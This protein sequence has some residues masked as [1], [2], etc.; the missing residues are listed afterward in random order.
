MKF[1]TSR[2]L[3]HLLSDVLICC[4]LEILLLWQR[5]VTTSPL[6]IYLDANKFGLLSFFALLETICQKVRAKPLLK[7]AK[8]PLPVDECRSKSPLLKLPIMY[9]GREFQLMF[10]QHLLH[11]YGYL[12]ILLM[13]KGVFMFFVCLFFFFHSQP[14]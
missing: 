12:F 10:S 9:T 5:D 4:H 14:P 2:I 11:S 3:I 13:S 8:S 6:C 7:N 1:E